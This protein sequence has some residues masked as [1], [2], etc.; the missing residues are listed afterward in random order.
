MGSRKETEKGGEAGDKAVE[1]QSLRERGMYG[2]RDRDCLIC[3]P[4]R[5]G[6]GMEI[7]RK[8][9]GNANCGTMNW[10]IMR[11]IGAIRAASYIGLQARS[12]E[13]NPGP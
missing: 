3:N 11:E 10:H 13:P 4:S 9:E 1:R 6:L 12:N 7:K 5:A 8:S 2:E